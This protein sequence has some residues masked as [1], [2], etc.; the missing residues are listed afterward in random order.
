LYVRVCN[1]RYDEPMNQTVKYIHRNL[2]ALR[3]EHHLSDARW[4][5]LADLNRSDVSRFTNG[6]VCN[7]KFDFLEKLC[8]ALGVTLYE[9][10]SK[11]PMATDA[12]SASERALVMRLR[13]MSDSQRDVVERMAEALTPDD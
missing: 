1:I 10:M 13:R 2:I 11:V 5:E 4:A 7:P 12:Y 8:A 9:V 3:D 6:H